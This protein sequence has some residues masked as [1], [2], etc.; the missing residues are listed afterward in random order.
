MIKYRTGGFGNKLI[1]K[2]E[3]ERETEVSVWINGRRNAKDSS[4]YKYF[5]SWN[6]AH[7]FLIEKAESDVEAATNRLRRASANLQKIKS[8]TEETK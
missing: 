2:V 1:E 8:L 5:N 6:E 4:W 7:S 3:V